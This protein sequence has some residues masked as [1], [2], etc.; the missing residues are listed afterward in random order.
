MRVEN[1]FTLPPD[2]ERDAPPPCS[3]RRSVTLAARA[4]GPSGRQGGPRRPGDKEGRAPGEDPIKILLVDDEPCALRAAARLLSLDPNVQLHACADAAAAESLAEEIRPTLILQDVVMPHAD[5]IS[6]VRAYRDN[7]VTRDVPV[8][9]LSSEEE[10]EV[11]AAAFAAGADDYLVKFPDGV[12]L[13]ARVRHHAR[14][15]QRR[16]ERERAVLTLA[17]RER[18]LSAETRFVRETF[19]RYLSD[20]IV[21]QLLSSPDALTLGGKRQRI[22]IMMTDLRGFTAISER[23]P[24]ERMV[25]LINI[26][27]GVMTEVILRHGGMVDEF[28]GDAILALFG[29]PSPRPDDAARA[30]ACAVAMQ[31]AM[32]EV[33][34]RSRAAG[35]P[36][37]EMGIGLHT[38]EVVLG[39]IGS[40]RR[41]KYA[42]VGAPVNLAARIESYT[43]GGQVLISEDTLDE[44]GDDVAIDGHLDVTPKGVTR[45]LR[46][47][48]VAGIRGRDSLCLPRPEVRLSAPVMDLSARFVVLE[49]KDASGARAEGRVVALGERAARIAAVA[50]GAGVHANV[51]LQLAAADGSAPA[52][53]IYAKITDADAEGITVRFTAVPVEAA[54]WL[55]GSAWR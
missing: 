48:R 39:N 43:L 10:P 42:V 6:M 9:M 2:D 27:L 38:G 40:S 1:G 34:A 19:A 15:Y 7:P 55:D 51:K 50:E 18:M 44:A 37:V 53:D 47:Y 25:T 14:N 4:V 41:A 45:P 35:L 36:E 3:G 12:E 11:K 20:G 21:E 26:Y 16:V 23:L 32:V 29:A 17:E 54:L 46:I 24:P 30:V 8:I 13:L 22:T 33:N 31:R 49:G 28:I 5:G 52:C